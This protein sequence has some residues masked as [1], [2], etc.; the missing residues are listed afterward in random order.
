M[1][2]ADQLNTDAQNDEGL[3]QWFR[4][5][6]AYVRRTLLEPGFV[7]SSDCNSDANSLRD[8]GRSFFEEKYRSHKDNLFD[9]IQAWF[10]AWGDD[11]LNK[12]FGNDW[13]RLTKDL[14]FSEE[15]NLTFKPALWNDIRKVIVPQ[16]A[17][18][19]GYI[20]SRIFS[21]VCLRQC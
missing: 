3:K 13:M 2:A 10:L 8:S 4:E 17:Q 12:R 20:V 6:D 5:L 1:H 18:H 14:L 7:L 11:P 9:A 15:G 16:L 19:I 21:L